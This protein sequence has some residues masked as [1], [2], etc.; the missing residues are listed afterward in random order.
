MWKLMI[1]LKKGVIFYRVLLAGD[2]IRI[3]DYQIDENLW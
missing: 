2:D 3:D 1:K